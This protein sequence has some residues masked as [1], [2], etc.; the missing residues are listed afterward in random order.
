MANEVEF[1]ARGNI[2]RG[3]RTLTLTVPPAFMDKLIEL[4]RKAGEKK[5]GMHITLKEPEKRRTTGRGSQNNHIHGHVAQMARE[6]GDGDVERML[7]VF[8]K[9]A[10]GR[11]YPFW[12]D[13]D[14][15]QIPRSLT[16]VTAKQAGCL[17]DTIHQEA[18]ELGIRLKED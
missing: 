11:G 10:I 5:K 18:D 15:N 13:D 17:I 8:K 2:S 4:A 12:V 1:V 9:M 14:G 6:T 7:F 16:K 3:N